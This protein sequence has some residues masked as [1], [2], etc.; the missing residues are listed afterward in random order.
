[1]RWGR[2]SFRLPSS[3]PETRLPKRR[4]SARPIGNRPQV[5]NP[6]HIKTGIFHEIFRA[7]GLDNRRQKPTV[8]ATLALCLD[9]CLDMNQGTIRPFEARDLPRIL[10]IENSSFGKEA[11]PAELFQE[12]ALESPKLFLVATAGR[13]LAG[14]SIACVR[15][16]TAE[17]ASIAV[18]PEYRGRGV[19]T[20][21]LR[22]TLRK[23][24]RQGATAM[25]LMV[26]SDNEPAIRLYRTF[27]FVRTATVRGYYEDGSSGW[28]MRVMLDKT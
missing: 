27:G 26:R 22:T 24:R 23:V 12:Y 4:N 13:R 8:R 21:L 9:Y 7:E 10:R 5:G 2:R 14:Y 19:A 11:W 18:L 6:P 3:A 28:R 15:R 25:W 1:M 17:L 20:K 16:Q